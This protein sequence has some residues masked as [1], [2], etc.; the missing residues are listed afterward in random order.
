MGGEVVSLEEFEKWF[1]V[2]VGWI[3]LKRIESI[4]GR[5]VFV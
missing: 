2:G 3:V 1:D 5:M 4:K